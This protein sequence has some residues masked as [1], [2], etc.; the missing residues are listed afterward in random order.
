MKTKKNTQSICFLGTGSDVGKSITATA[1][2]RILKNR[3]FKVAFFK[4]QNMSN[5]S[6]V[7]FEGGEIGRA[8]VAQAEAAGCLPSVHMNP[9][10][11]K[12][13]SDVGS[14]VVVLGKA[15]KTMQATEYYG[16]NETLRK[17]VFESF[18]RLAGEYEAIVI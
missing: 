3:G 13:S 6:Y 2:C 12:P 18:Q 8:R 11:L 15:Q 4:A 5:N 1:F 17:T 7:T 16:Y 9:V 10:L 14:Q